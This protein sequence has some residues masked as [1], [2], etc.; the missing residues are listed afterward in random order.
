MRRLGSSGPSIMQ[1]NFPVYVIDDD[2]Q[3]RT[4][5]ET[6]LGAH[7]FAVRSFADG[8]AF[9]SHQATLSPGVV[10][11]DWL[12]PG[13]DGLG[14]LASLPGRFRAVLHTACVTA[15]GHEQAT[16]LGAVSVLE[17]PCTPS[18]LISSVF[19]AGATL[20]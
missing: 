10:L 6:L 19:E 4:S 16:Q 17:K 15:E 3:L 2:A 5:I 13:I 7:G 11:V 9:L 12:M 1:P 20:A 8:Q 14:V 18:D